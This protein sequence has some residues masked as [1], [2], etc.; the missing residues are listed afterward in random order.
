MTTPNRPETPFDSIE[1]A[2]DY[3]SL[4][5]QSL[6]EARE[7]ILEDVAKARET[8]AKRRLDALKI[9]TY[10]LDRLED[11]LVAGRRLLNDLRTLRRLLLEE[12]HGAADGTSPGDNV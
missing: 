3:V 6:E 10:K 4:L 12:R 1:G 5:C 9:V 7:S 11:H 8:G 2:Y